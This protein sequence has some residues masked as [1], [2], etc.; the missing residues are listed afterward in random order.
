MFHAHHGIIF[1]WITRGKEIVSA[2]KMRTKRT[3]WGVRAN[4]LPLSVSPFLTCKQT[5]CRS[6]TNSDP[7]PP[8]ISIR[9][10]Y[11]NHSKRSLATPI[12]SL[13]HLC[14]A[15]C[16]GNKAWKDPIRVNISMATPQTGSRW[17]C[18]KLLTRTTIHNTPVISA[19]QAA[20]SRIKM[21]Q[22]CPLSSI[23]SITGCKP[24]KALI[25]YRS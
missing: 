16:I 22:S 17:S 14:Q 5:I 23:F 13:S 6:L 2:L 21:P 9:L 7:S 4:Q 18:T 10:S 1:R 24:D 11:E 25:A 12:A 15:P 3:I 8:N 20:R 19:K